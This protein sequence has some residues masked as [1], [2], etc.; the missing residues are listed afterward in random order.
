MYINDYSDES[1]DEVY[2]YIFI[3]IMRTVDTSSHTKEYDVTDIHIYITLLYAYV[4][5]F[6]LSYN[7][8][9]YRRL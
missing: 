3:D 2:I 1:D 4:I 6:L 9:I 7:T 8:F 5:L